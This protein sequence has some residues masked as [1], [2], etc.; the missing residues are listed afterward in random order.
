[1]HRT[2][3]LL[4]SLTCTITR[5]A[6]CQAPPPTHD[7]GFQFL[8]GGTLLKP[9]IANP[10]EPRVGVRKEIGT[11]QLKLD[12]GS[13]VDFV[14]FTANKSGTV[15]LRMGADFFTFALTTSAQGLRLQVA[16]VDGFFGGHIVM[17]ADDGPRSLA[18]RL[19]LM[20]LSAH[21]IDGNFDVATGQWKD[22]RMPIPFTRDFGELVAA[23]AFPIW[24]MPMLV[25]SGVVYATLVRPGDIKRIA[26]I[27][28]LEIRTDDQFPKVFGRPFAIYGAFNVT[29]AGV[30][31]Y[32]A[33]NVI[34]AGVKFGGWDDIGLK[35][36][37]NYISGLDL[38]SQF[39]NVHRAMWGTG[40]TIDFY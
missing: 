17:R 9:L 5:I 7:E 40:F 6:V 25:Y 12:I 21:L 10:Q 27:H 14:Q 32:V 8:P 31:A 1:M 37:V 4:F 23:Y 38:F 35:F 29:L 34:E 22:G 11:A 36:Y 3:W 26:S 24:T 28:G 33:T 15:R 13:M 30:P 2:T 19:R 16:A 18:L 20:H 39:Y